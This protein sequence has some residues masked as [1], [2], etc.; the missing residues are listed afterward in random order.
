MNPAKDITPLPSQARMDS[1]H[2]GSSFATLLAYTCVVS[3]SSPA[4]THLKPFFC[5]GDDGWMRNFFSGSGLLLPKTIP[6]Q[7]QFQCR[8]PGRKEGQLG[9][10]G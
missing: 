3:I 2:C 8:I 9:G 1:T 6:A 10:G 7:D 4:S 5:I